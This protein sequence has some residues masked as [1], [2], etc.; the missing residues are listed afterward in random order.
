M[1]TGTERLPQGAG[2][3]RAAAVNDAR[4][5]FFL[6]PRGAVHESSK[7]KWTPLFF[8]VLLGMFVLLIVAVIGWSFWLEGYR[9][10]W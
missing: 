9:L 5:E 1:K 10:P 6:P 3:G 7:R 8:G 4:S 2:N